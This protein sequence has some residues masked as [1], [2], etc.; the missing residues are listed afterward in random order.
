MCRDYASWDGPFHCA[1]ILGIL[2]G[3]KEAFSCH[4]YRPFESCRCRK[5]NVLLGN[6]SHVLTMMETDNLIN[7]FLCHDL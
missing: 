1:C 6:I 3:T 7:F 4:L 5:P 2:Q